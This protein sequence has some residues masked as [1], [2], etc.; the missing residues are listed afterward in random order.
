MSDKTISV[1][2]AARNFADCVNRAH[3]QGITFILHK[4]GVPV[5][6]IGPA[7]KALEDASAGNGPALLEAL[8]KARIE[9]GLT[10]EDAELW[11]HDLQGARAGLL[12]PRDKWQS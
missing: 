2:D 7:S 1:T 9:S 10:P 5:A 12:P 11:L 3:Y 6:R 8:R 4:N